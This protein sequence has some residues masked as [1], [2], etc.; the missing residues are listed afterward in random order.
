MI[1]TLSPQ[2]THSRQYFSLEALDI[3][4]VGLSALRLTIESVTLH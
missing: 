4:G 1:T 3:D 2:A